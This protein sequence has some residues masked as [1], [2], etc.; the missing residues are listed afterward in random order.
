MVGFKRNE[1]A[2]DF[3]RQ[4]F[5]REA[6]R[7]GA[8]LWD[9]DYDPSQDNERAR[10]AFR[11]AGWSEEETEQRLKD[12]HDIAAEA[13]EPNSGVNPGAQV[14][15]KD[16][17]RDVE[18]AMARLGLASHETVAHGIEPRIGPFAAKLNVVMTEESV[19]TVGAHLFRYCGLV[20]RAFTRTLWLNP[21]MWSAEDYLPK[22]GQLKLA[23]APELV[24]YWA[25]AYLSYAATGT[26]VL[27]PFKPSRKHEVI[28]MELIAR[29]METFA[30]AHEYGHHHL[31]HGRSVGSEGAHD[32]EFE[33]DQFA[34]RICREVEQYPVLAENPYLP[35]G[36]GGAI[37]LLSL[38]T[39]RKIESLIASSHRAGRESHPDAH[40][41]VR[42][43]DSVAI[44]Q[45]AEFAQLKGFRDTAVR[46]MDTVESF[47]LLAFQS[48]D[49]RKLCGRSE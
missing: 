3:W 45:P 7:E 47:M 13:E 32:E 16:L 42:R 44:L 39:L 2:K 29:S 37:L 26:N 17:C 22:D 25:D 28:L 40:E 48:A 6:Q 10:A 33:A 9:P 43:F 41:R 27:A 31:N 12:Y 34:L 14:I 15:Y 8:A 1:T 20:A 35:S 49:F 38:G 18:A 11:D 46:I 4:V 5:A 19:I 36:A 21:Y 30:I 24:R 23:R